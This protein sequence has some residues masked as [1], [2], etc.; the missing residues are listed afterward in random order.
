[1]A[2][3]SEGKIFPSVLH[4]SMKFHG[5]L[6]EGASFGTHLLALKLETCNVILIL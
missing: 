1:M 4:T 2:S 3:C 6:E 5:P